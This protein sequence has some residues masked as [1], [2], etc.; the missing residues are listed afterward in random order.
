MKRAKKFRFRLRLFV[1]EEYRPLRATRPALW[2]ALA[3]CLAAQAGHNAAF[4]PQPTARAEDLSRPPGEGVFRVAALGDPAAL[5]R[6]VMLSLQSFDNQPGISVPFQDLNYEAVTEWLSIASAL[7]PRSDYPHFAA[8]RA[9]GGVRDPARKRVMIEWI[10]GEFV[11]DPVRR[12]EW[13]AHAVT[14]ARHGLLKDRAL[15]LELARQLREKTKPGEAPNWARQ[16]EAFLL[17]NDDEYAAASELMLNLLEEGEIQD[18]HEYRL[19][20]D[21]LREMLEKTEARD[22]LAS[23]RELKRLENRLAP[24]MEAQGEGVARE[25][26]ALQLRLRG[27]LERMT[28]RN[29]LKPCEEFRRQ[30]SKLGEIAKRYAKRFGADFSAGTGE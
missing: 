6:A 5:S 30:Q 11:Q 4:L 3:L 29:E 10:R 27:L 22:E 16:M 9:Y 1:E 26:D 25:F 13:M 2:L 23:C 19:M 20:Y 17:R 18:V 24:L 7:D 28:A 21:R 8:T 14:D 12:W 15:S